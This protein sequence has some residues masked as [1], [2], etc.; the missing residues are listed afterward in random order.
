M[1]IAY[2]NSASQ[3]DTSNSD[4]NTN[5]PYVISVGDCVVFGIAKATLVGVPSVVTDNGASGGN[6]YTLSESYAGIAPAL[7]IFTTIATVSA[8]S[9]FPVWTVGSHTAMSASRYS[10][11]ASIG[12]NKGSAHTNLVTT[13][14]MAAC[15]LAN[16]NNW[17]VLIEAHLFAGGAPSAATGNLRVTSAAIATDDYNTMIDNTGSASVSNTD[18]WGVAANF[19][20]AYIELVP[21]AVASVSGG[22]RMPVFFVGSKSG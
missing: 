14:G 15:T 1:A 17:A 2:L 9:I 20:A 8:T 6:T 10:G 7:Y 12:S 18:T 22:G 19:S 4:T 16:A 3:N 11:V 13:G 21:T 5:F